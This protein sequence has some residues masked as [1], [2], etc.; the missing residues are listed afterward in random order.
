MH[1]GFCLLTPRHTRQATFIASNSGPASPDGETRCYGFNT[2]L[3]QR[4]LRA[5][6]R[7]WNE[8]RIAKRPRLQ[9]KRLSS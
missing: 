1:R 6:G 7:N 3:A 8:G 4:E 2:P 9:Q 5:W